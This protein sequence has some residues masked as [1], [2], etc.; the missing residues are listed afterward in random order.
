MARSTPTCRMTNQEV[1]ELLDEVAERL[2][3]QAANPFRVAAYR[4]AADTVRDW[5]RPI[6]DLLIEHGVT[7]LEAIPHIGKSLAKTI[8]ELLRQGRC[9]SLEKLRQKQSARDVLT[10]L[11]TVGPR[12]ADRIRTS[13]GATTLEEV[14]AAA[15]DGR[16]RRVAGMGRKRL[17]AIRESL[18]LR[19]NHPAPPK[20]QIL[21]PNPPPV[22]VLL[23]L[24]RIYR[25]RAV[26]GRLITVAPRRFNPTGEAWLPVLRIKHNGRR[27]CVY[28]A[29]SARSHQLDHLHDWVV[30]YCLEKEDFGRW[31]VITSTYGRLRGRRIVRGREAECNAHYGQAPPVQLSLLPLSQAIG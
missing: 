11:P 15:Y 3:A 21:G 9:A 13:L 18:S 17:Q 5:Q 6:V 23:E 24:D 10:S 14:Y 8:E 1:A 29:N 22:E 12:M 20:R 16:L 25:Q 28:Y 26:K 2:H 4:N 27:Y 30:I 19:L 31:T 7:G